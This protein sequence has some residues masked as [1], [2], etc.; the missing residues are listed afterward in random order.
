MMR[1][2][3]SGPTLERISKCFVIPGY[4]KSLSWVWSIGNFVLRVKGEVDASCGG[5]RFKME[6]GSR[7]VRRS[8]LEDFAIKAQS[9]MI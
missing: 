2:P 6:I 3:R 5:P 9:N 4:K 7:E 8:Y 1:I